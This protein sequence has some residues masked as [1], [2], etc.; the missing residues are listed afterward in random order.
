ME[1]TNHNFPDNVLDSFRLDGRRAVITGGAK[2]LGQVIGMALAQAGADVAIAI[3][4]GWSG[5]MQ[6]PACK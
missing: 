2:G 4:S 6:K 3:T 1:D 5:Y